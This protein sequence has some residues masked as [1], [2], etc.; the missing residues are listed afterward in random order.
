MVRM[1]V[2]AIALA[3]SFGGRAN[4]SDDFTH[5]VLSLSWNA[6]WC[7]IEGDD[8]RAE[9]C[10]PRH[11][12]GFVLHGLWPQGERDW[13][14]YCRT[15]H[16]DPSRR[17]S[18]RMADIMGSPGLAWYQW[19]KHGRC[20]DLPAQDYFALAR[21]AFEMIEK[22]PVLRKLDKQ[23]R[24]SARVVEDAFLDVNP[25]LRAN[26]ISVTCRDGYVQEVRVCL[27]KALVP[28]A[29]TAKVERGCQAKSSLLP[30]I[31]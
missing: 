10:D 19:K 1:L 13:P 23:V 14:E 3:T 28:R 31:R 16:A 12:Y 6:S 21:E 9:Q 2:L 4:A 18:A 26:Q 7:E 30:P 25:N 11:D 17:Q 29:C 5:Y 20:S 27:S 15:G 8:R 22:P 24:V